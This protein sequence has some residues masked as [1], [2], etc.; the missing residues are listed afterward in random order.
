MAQKVLICPGDVENGPEPVCSR[1][2]SR[3]RDNQG[4]PQLIRRMLDPLRL[5]SKAK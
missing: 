2:P 3:A 4:C 1:E 5:F